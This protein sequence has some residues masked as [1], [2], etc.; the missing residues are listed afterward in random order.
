MAKSDPLPKA[1]CR[2]ELPEDGGE[3]FNRL[4]F[5]KSPYLLQHATNPVDWYPWGAEAFCRAA[6]ENRPVFLSIGYATCHWCHVMAHES[7][8]DEEVAR[9]LNENFIAIKVDKEERP[10][11]DDI[12]MAACLMMNGHGGWPLTVLLAPNQKP[13][14]TATYLPKHSRAGRLGMM[15]FL[16]RIANLW[17]ARKTALM[18]DSDRL[19]AAI[20]QFG[21]G[22]QTGRTESAAVRKGFDQL[23]S[24][25]DAELGGFGN[26]PKFPTAHHFLFLLRAEG[27]PYG[28]MAK[29]IVCRSLFAM[30]CGG[31]FDQLGMGFHRYSTDREWLLPHFEKMLYDQ[32]MLAMAY[33]EAWQ[34][35]GEPWM[36]QTAREIFQ[37]VLRDLTGSDGGFYSAEDADS[38]G[39]EGKFYV[40]HPDEIFDV[41]GK[42]LGE[43]FC[44]TYQVTPEGN[45]H[46]EA[47]GKALGTSI[48]HIPMTD[49][50]GPFQLRETRWE[51]RHEGACRTL[52]EIR[53]S[54]I[55][56]LKD[57]KILT[58]WNG[59]MIAA[60]AMGSRILGDASFLEAAV[61]AAGFISAN[62]TSPSGELLKRYRDG[63]AGLPAHLDDYAFCALGWLELY[64]AGFDID[65]LKKCLEFIDIAKK[66]FWNDEK[67]AFYMTANNGEPLIA[68][69]MKAHDGAIPS[70]NSVLAY[71]M[72]FLGRMLGRSG[73]EDDARHI[74]DAFAQT[75]N[76]SA[77]NSTYLLMAFDFLESVTQEVVIVGDRDHPR[78]KALLVVVGE[79]FRPFTS[80]LIKAPQDQIMAE[81]APFTKAMTML[82]GRP[83]AYVCQAQACEMPVTGPES[84]RVQ[85]DGQEPTAGD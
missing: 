14:F 32:A 79:K 31:I 4:I 34:A 19:T 18:E 38:E 11:I 54:R 85:L 5:E 40:W 61:K 80:V 1:R 42:D 48:L 50:D 37:Y 57:D 20:R 10:D 56:P 58:D 12:Y 47:T 27:R 41:L 25:F 51:R 16:P 24:H 72:A 6:E 59:L 39:E 36:A 49:P 22:E 71:V 78:T 75:L 46:D 30:R 55:H 29:T 77:M 60:L 21:E 73:L 74:V 62:L 82:E 15:D 68:R 17:Q 26:A 45:F 64:R 2:D 53:E 28:G 81:L 65:H 76:G 67:G 52:F 63:D 3:A 66:Q 9:L 69:S 83:A 84:F 23:V 7:F 44:S 35:Y 33:L 13:F 43:V 70:G 8:E